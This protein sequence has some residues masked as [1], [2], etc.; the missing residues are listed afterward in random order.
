M[1]DN[2]TIADII[3]EMRGDKGFPVPYAPERAVW[4]NNI[5]IYI[6]RLEAA[7]GR[8]RGN[9]AAL[10]EALEKIAHYDDDRD[11]MDDPGCADGHICADI[12]RKAL[13]DLGEVLDE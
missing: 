5:T 10:H 12:A 13:A 11:G 8:E 3:A 1:A 4:L 7:H 9:V 6:D 2:E